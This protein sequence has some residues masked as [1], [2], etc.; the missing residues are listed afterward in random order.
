M[1]EDQARFIKRLLRKRPE[2]RLS[3]DAALAIITAWDRTGVLD[4]GYYGSSFD[5]HELEPDAEGAPMFR[6]MSMGAPIDF[7][8][9]DVEFYE[10]SLSA[11]DKM[12]SKDSG[13]EQRAGK[14]KDWSQIEKL[15]RNYFDEL[16][17]S[18][19][20]AVIAIKDMGSL[21]ITGLQADGKIRVD[22]KIDGN[23]MSWKLLESTL[24]E[25]VQ[26]LDPMGRADLILPE[27]GGVNY[28]SDKIIEV[29]RTS[30]G[31]TPPEIRIY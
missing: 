5:V 7:D 21:G 13:F 8:S 9:D 10:E 14:S 11:V 24:G 26:V 2:D 1:D 15:I 4:L 27:V 29:L 18:D 17:G 28:L 12:H 19:F 6:E 20:S 3:A 31:D 22:F 23:F 25:N 16:P 30:F